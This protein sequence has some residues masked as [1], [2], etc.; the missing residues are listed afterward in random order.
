METLKGL[1]PEQQSTEKMSF[2]AKVGYAIAGMATFMII[3]NVAQA[4]F[5]GS[6]DLSSLELSL[7]Q[8][9]EQA[10]LQRAKILEEQARLVAINISA[11]DEKITLANA[12][13]Q[14]DLKEGKADTKRLSEK[15]SCL[16][17]AINGSLPENV[18]SVCDQDVQSV[19]KELT[20]EEISGFTMEQPRQ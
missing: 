16:V 9:Y 13:M 7:A 8:K 6:V 12:K 17:T 3:V 1:H 14:K 19:S 4:A 15:I 18:E 10:D 11:L 20:S 5:S 2:G